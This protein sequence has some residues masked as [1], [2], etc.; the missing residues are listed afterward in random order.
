MLAEKICLRTPGYGRELAGLKREQQQALDVQELTEQQKT[1]I[2]ANYVQKRVDLKQKYSLVAAQA[3]VANIPLVWAQANAAS[4]KL[5][6]DYQRQVL[7][8]ILQSSAQATQIQIAAA[9]EGSVR[10]QNLEPV[11]IKLEQE[12]A[13][14]ALDRRAMFDLEYE[15]RITAVRADAVAKRKALSEQDT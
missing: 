10:R 3:A 2:T 5:E 12:V 7:S 6:A 1:E 8:L 4:L 15:T 11:N 14:A 13:I 9:K